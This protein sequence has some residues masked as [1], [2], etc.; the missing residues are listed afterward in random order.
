MTTSIVPP[1]VFLPICPVRLPANEPRRSSV[2][3]YR[4]LSD[5][6]PDSAE[7]YEQYQLFPFPHGSK[8]EPK[9]MTLKEIIADI[10]NKG[11][12]DDFSHAILL[13][14]YKYTYATLHPYYVHKEQARRNKKKELARKLAEQLV[15]TQTPP[16]N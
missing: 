4:W 10:S 14:L 9:W 1:S 15:G 6:Q 5:L 11:Y 8:N 7:G 3:P 13:P 16:D 12:D 2:T